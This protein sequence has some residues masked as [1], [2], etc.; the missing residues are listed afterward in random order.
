MVWNLGTKKLQGGVPD[1]RA[2]LVGL[3]VGE[4]GI[5]VDI[6]N[7]TSYWFMNEKDKTTGGGTTLYLDAHPT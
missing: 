7:R 6:S 3:E 4:L 1:L 5:W 2:D